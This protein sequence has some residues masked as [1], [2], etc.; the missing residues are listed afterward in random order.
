MPTGT[1]GV[2]SGD[3]ETGGTLGEGRTGGLMTG[4]P[5][6]GTGSDGSGVGDGR[7]STAAT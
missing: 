5:A 4:T 3:M 1:D 6:E 2:G 7:P